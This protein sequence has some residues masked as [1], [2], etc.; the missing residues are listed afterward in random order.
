MIG[1]KNHCHDKNVKIFLRVFNIYTDH[2]IEANK[3]DIIIKNS[4][5]M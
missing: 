1:I 3:P 4:K 5:T 2:I